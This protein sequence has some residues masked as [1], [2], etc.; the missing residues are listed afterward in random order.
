MGNGSFGLGTPAF[1]GIFGFSGGCRMGSSEEEG[2]VVG[3][4][5]GGGRHVVLAVLVVSGFNRVGLGDW[6]MAYVAALSGF[7]PC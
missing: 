6:F 4:C 2:V 7:K 1:L 3:L 5:H